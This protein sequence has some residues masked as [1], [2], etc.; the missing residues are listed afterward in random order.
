MRIL[1]AALP[2]ALALAACVSP[3]AAPADPAARQLTDADLTA[4]AAKPWDKAAMMF[5]HVVLGVHHGLEV[6]ADFPC[7]D[8]CPNYTT[9]IIHYAADP[10][11]ACQTA[12]GVVITRGVP[13]SIAEMQKQFCVPKVLAQQ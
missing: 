10:G 1:P 8:V 2:A 13:V 4:Y 11:P 6:V 9:R 5:K 7:G 3:S 12:G